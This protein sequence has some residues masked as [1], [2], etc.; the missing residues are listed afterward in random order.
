MKK[1]LLSAALIS[2]C[3]WSFAKQVSPENAKVVAQNFI[4]SKT[5]QTPSLELVQSFG[6]N[7]PLVYVFSYNIDKG[8]VVVSGDDIVTPILGY[9]LEN[10]FPISNISPEVNYWLNSYVSQI[11]YAQNQTNP[12]SEEVRTKW[13]SLQ[14]PTVHTANKATAVT[15]M[16]QTKWNQLPYYNLL[17]P[18]IPSGSQVPYDNAPAG[19]VATAMSQI[20]KYWENPTTGT[21]SRTYNSST[22]GGTLTADFGN[23]TYDWAD[24]PNTLNQ[25]SSAIQKNAIATLMYHCGVAVKMDYDVEGSGAYVISYG[26]NNQ[27][28]SENALKNN[29][30]YKSTIKGYPRADFTDSTWIK[31][32]KFELDN[33]RPLLYTGAG[34]IGGHAFVFDGYD[35][36]DMFHINWG[37]GGMSDGYFIVDA[38]SPSAL[39]TGGGAGNFNFYQEALIM[40]EPANSILP[41]NPF[42]PDFTL[43]D[44][45]LILN[46]DPNSSADSII[47]GTPYSLSA[48]IHNV[49]SEAFTNNNSLLIIAINPSNPN[50]NAITLKNITTDILPDSV[51]NFSFSTQN[52]TALTPGTYV[53]AFIYVDQQQN[54]DMLYNPTTGGNAAMLTVLPQSTDPANIVQVSTEKVISVFPNPASSSVSIKTVDAEDKIQALYL[55]DIQGKVL[56]QK[57]ALSAD[58]FQLNTE[59]Y[60]N[61][62]YF[63]RIQTN[64]GT[65][66]QKITIKK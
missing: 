45:N 11:E 26:S 32:L 24:M 6:G 23:T 54:G 40:I 63:V 39:G 17:C 55:T 48:E 64:K 12:G 13:A 36:S 65:F 16:V 2:I 9:S 42:T 18:A 19:C 57:E 61:G 14:N 38:L 33:E 37:W 3:S 4:S 1:L 56:F 46:S 58:Y 62:I 29:F 50:A 15:P 22:L 34:Q 66:A 43:P 10:A 7:T 20:M 25:S 52:M 31:M 8:F 49:G 28:C 44:F 47:F 53:I 60:A 35:N 41:A 5:T 21:G 30:G 27:A 51:F 59:A